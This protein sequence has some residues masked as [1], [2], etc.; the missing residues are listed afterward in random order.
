MSTH[1][2]PGPPRLIVGAA[3]IGAF[4]GLTERQ[5][6]HLIETG[7]LPVVRLGRR[8]AARPATLDR[9]LDERERAATSRP[10]VA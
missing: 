10:R 7:Q 9:W 2:A 6:L 3:E 5:V 4:L 8:L 1:H